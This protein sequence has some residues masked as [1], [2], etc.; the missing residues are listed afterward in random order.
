MN[1]LPSKAG[2]AGSIPGQGTKVP[3][4]VGH[5]SPHTPTTE[6]TC[7]AAQASQLEKP[8]HCKEDLGHPKK[9]TCPTLYHCPT[10]WQMHTSLKIGIDLT[11]E[12]KYQPFKPISAVCSFSKYL[13]ASL[14][15][16]WIRSLLPMQETW[17]R[18]L[19]QED[20]TCCGATKPV[21]PNAC[22]LQQG[23]TTAG[24]GIL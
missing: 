16:Q 11:L 2:D 22:A 24:A 17:L 8:T 19:I 18:S 3:P 20:P 21:C 6:P 7:F 1:N 12:Q 5:L 4:A 23:D 10:H 9:A 14:V 15:A 13:Q